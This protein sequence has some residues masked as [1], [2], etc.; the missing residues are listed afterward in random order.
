MVHFVI[1]YLKTRKRYRKSD[2]IFGKFT[3]FSIDITFK[4]MGV[5]P[6]IVP[7]I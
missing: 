7:K 1:K 4:I 6:N 5:N 3:L 2:Y